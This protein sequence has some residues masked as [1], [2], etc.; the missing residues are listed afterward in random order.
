[1]GLLRHTGFPHELRSSLGE[2][3]ANNLIRDTRTSIYFYLQFLGSTSLAASKTKNTILVL[4]CPMRTGGIAINCATLDGTGWIHRHSFS[5]PLPSKLVKQY[6][7]RENA[8][9]VSIKLRARVTCS[10]H[11]LSPPP[12]APS[13]PTPFQTTLKNDGEG[14]PVRSRDPPARGARVR[15]PDGLCQRL[16]WEQGQS[17]FCIQ[18]SNGKAHDEHGA[19][20]H[21]DQA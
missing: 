5:R 4:L 8:S 21:H 20:V 1:M 7:G 9:Q 19:V 16:R 13:P 10:V 6:P 11:A 15:G 18:L 14:S 17:C 2:K 3:P 12:A